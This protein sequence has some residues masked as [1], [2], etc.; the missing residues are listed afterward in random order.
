[1]KPFKLSFAALVLVFALMG[2]SRADH[3]TIDPVHS[4]I[5]FSVKHLAIS[6]VTGRFDKF[7]GSFEFDPKN[8]KASRGSVKIDAAS[9]NTDVAQRDN[10][11]K[12]PNFLD[13]AKYPDITFVSKKVTDMKKGK[14]R[15]FGDL[16]MHG[17]TRPVLL[18]VEYGG[19]TQFPPGTQRVAFTASTVINRQDFGMTFNRALET[20][21]LIV[22]N[23]VKISLE[24]EAMKKKS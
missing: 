18:N 5:S 21:G 23:E 14:F 15:V 9:I 4:K 17:V 13:V 16:T 6:T 20:G 3:Y 24:I 12:S 2:I 7:S 22:G 19:M 10:D 1:M 8:V 11:L